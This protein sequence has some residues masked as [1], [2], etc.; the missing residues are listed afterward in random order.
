MGKISTIGLSRIDSKKVSN[1]LRARFLPPDVQ[2]MVERL[3]ALHV[4]FAKGS[5]RSDVAR[6][7]SLLEKTRGEPS[8]GN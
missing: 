6:R 3:M 2:I 8:A 4:V 7:Y 1:S 5:V